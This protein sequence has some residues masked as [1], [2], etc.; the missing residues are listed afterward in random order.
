MKKWQ[1]ECTRLPFPFSVDSVKTNEVKIRDEQKN[2]LQPWHVS[3][4]IDI[5][6]LHDK[7]TGFDA[8]LFERDV[9]GKKQVVVFRGRD[10]R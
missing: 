1:V 9:D 10:I 8:F 2:M 5:S 7:K 3:N 4:E 6:L